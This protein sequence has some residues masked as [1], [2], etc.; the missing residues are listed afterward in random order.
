VIKG[1]LTHEYDRQT[2]FLIA[3]V[4]L[5][6]PKTVLDLPADTIIA[7][8]VLKTGSDSKSWRAAGARSASPDS[9]GAELGRGTGH[10]GGRRGR[11]RGRW[12]AVNGG[13]RFVSAAGLYPLGFGI[14]ILCF[15]SSVSL[16]EGLPYYCH[17]YFKAFRRI[18]NFINCYPLDEK[19]HGKLCCKIG[20][21]P[22]SGL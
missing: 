16:C 8:H 3:N 12:M 13:P 5:L 22:A 6:R 18:N 11:G 4:A 10:R 19:L 2:D 17:V 7:D 20:E 1:L 21:I 9:R 15:M 14:V